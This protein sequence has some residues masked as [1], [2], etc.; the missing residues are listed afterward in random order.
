MTMSD[1]VGN[2]SSPGEEVKEN[3]KSRGTW[4]RLAYMVLFAV[5]FWVAESVLIVVAV[6]QFLWK[7]F[8][9][10]TNA[11]LTVFGENLGRYLYQIVR[12]LTFNS[13]EMPF[14]FADWPGAAPEPES[15]PKRKKAITPKTE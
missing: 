4:L 13:E 12:F 9:A 14:P 15:K 8:S 11:R 2:D 7:L 6:L 3:L 5:L 10:D 1:Q